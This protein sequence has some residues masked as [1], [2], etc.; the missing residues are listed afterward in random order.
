MNNKNFKLSAQ[1]FDDWLIAARAYPSFC[2]MKWIRVFLLP[3]DGMLVHQRSLPRNLGFP[4]NSPVPIYI[5]YTWVE[6]STVTVKCLDQEHNTVF[7]ARAWSWTA[8]SRD[9]HTN[10]EATAPALLI[11]VTTQKSSKIYTSHPL[12]MFT[13]Y[14]IVKA[15]GNDNLNAFWEYFLQSVSQTHRGPI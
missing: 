1:Y 3:L 7:L 8:R 10:H 14:Y 13:V 6:R 2:S 4:N 15:S 12:R 9:E 5:V 11:L